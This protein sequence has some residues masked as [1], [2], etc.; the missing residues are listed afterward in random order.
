MSQRVPETRTTVQQTRTD[1]RTTPQQQVQQQQVTRNVDDR[2]EAVRQLETLREKGYYRGPQERANQY[3]YNRAQQYVMEDA[4]VTEERIRSRKVH[5]IIPTVTREHEVTEVRHAVLPIKEKVRE[6][7]T[8]SERQLSDIRGREYRVGYNEEERMKSQ[9]I[10]QQ[11]AR[12][13]REELEAEH[14]YIYNRPVVK[15]VIRPR[16]VH[17]IHPVVQ[18]EIEREHHERQY[19][20]V[21]ERIV[22]GPRVR[23]DVEMLPALSREEW[24]ARRTQGIGRELGWQPIRDEQAIWQ[25]FRGGNAGMVERDTSYSYS[26]GPNSFQR[27]VRREEYPIRGGGG[28]DNRF[29]N[30]FDQRQGFG[31]PQNYGPGFNNQS[32]GGQGYNQGYG[33]QGYDQEFRARHHHHR[34]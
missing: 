20:P 23:E 34:V 27:E 5:E 17:E 9:R 26:S 31:G 33:N 25:G 10:G 24:E 4:P 12:A 18:R 30:D 8:Y 21:H 22:E 32:Y 15:E 28:F 7:L 6:D 13:T 2:G 29:R 3:E 11:V 16:I 19:L 1:I 14:E